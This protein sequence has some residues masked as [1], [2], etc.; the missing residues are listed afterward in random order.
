MRMRI[1]PENVYV[2]A[3]RAHG[4]NIGAK[5]TEDAL[6]TVTSTHRQHTH[7]LT[8]HSHTIT[9]GSDLA[10]QLNKMDWILFAHFVRDS[11]SPEIK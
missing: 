8:I 11:K 10:L 3:K 1:G 4:D 6:L 9:S 2:Y 5:Q 7:T